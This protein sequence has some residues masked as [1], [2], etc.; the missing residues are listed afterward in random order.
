MLRAA[1]NEDVIAITPGVPPQQEY[2]THE[3]NISKMLARFL[4]HEVGTTKGVRVVEGGYLNLVS[5]L[6]IP[7]VRKAGA[8]Y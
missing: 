3:Y 5:L 6:A 7:K 2:T 4:R 8:T 1:S